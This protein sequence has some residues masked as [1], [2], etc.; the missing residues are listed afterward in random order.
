MYEQYI[1]LPEFPGISLPEERYLIARAQKG[2]KKE[3]DELILRHIGFIAF[4]IRKKV[5]YDYRERFGNDILSEAVF[6]LYDKIGSYNLNY[7]DKHGDFKPVRF[8]S[9]IWKRIDGFIL[10]FLQEIRIREEK[11]IRMNP[12]N[13]SGSIRPFS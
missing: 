11:H 5:F 6:I 1:N 9:Y 2:Y 4:R 10:D 12:E 8:S 7:K 13:F 3:T